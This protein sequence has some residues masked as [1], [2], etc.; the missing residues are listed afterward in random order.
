MSTSTDFIVATT[1]EFTSDVQLGDAKLQWPDITVIVA[2]FIMI[3]VVG[4]WVS[5]NSD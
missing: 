2:Y 1:T 4:F 3:L 5:C